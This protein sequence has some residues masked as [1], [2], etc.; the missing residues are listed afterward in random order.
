LCAS[1]LQEKYLLNAMATLYSV[2]DD[3]DGNSNTLAS[4]KNGPLQNGRTAQSV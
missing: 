2:G 1:L 3:A 4:K